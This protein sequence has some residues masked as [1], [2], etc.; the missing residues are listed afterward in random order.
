[1][2]LAMAA[3]LALGL[4]AVGVSAQEPTPEVPTQEEAAQEEVAR[5]EAAEEEAV[6]EEATP[7]EPERWSGEVGLSVNGSGGNEN[8]TVITSELRLT[9]LLTERYELDFQGRVR[10]GRSE[11]TEVARS[12][13]ASINAELHPGAAWSPFLFATAEHDPFRR[14]E[15]R[16]NSGAGAKHTFWRDGWNDVSLSGAVLYS[17]QRLEVPDTVGSGIT[18][19]ARWSWRGRARRQIQEGTR[20]EQVI[21]YQPEWNQ[22]Y[23]YLLEA[24]TSGRM[25]L[26][27]SLALIST[28]LYQRNSIP[29]PDVAPDDWSITVGLSLSTNW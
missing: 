28:F 5:E 2:T 7:E 25:A 24:R 13:R 19:T 15:V 16:L 20:V 8:L 29:A 18:N 27:Q 26:S 11:G 17:H 1:M 4:S 3:L 23:D 10:Y 9:H 14:L 6:E 22:L 12:T 21:F